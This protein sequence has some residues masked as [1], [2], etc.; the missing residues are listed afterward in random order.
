MEL[1]GDLGQIEFVSVRL[2]MKLI[3]KHDR[4]TVCAECAIGSEIVLGAPDGTSR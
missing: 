4:G 2:E 3:L 1:L